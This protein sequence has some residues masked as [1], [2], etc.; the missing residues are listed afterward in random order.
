MRAEV[1]MVLN[2]AGGRQWRQHRV[3]LWRSVEVAQGV[4]SRFLHALRALSPE[5]DLL[6]GAGIGNSLRAD[7]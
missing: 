5:L 3:A 4:P 1:L 7:G 2:S 6:H